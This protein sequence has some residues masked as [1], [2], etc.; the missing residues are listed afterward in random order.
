MVVPGLAVFGPVVVEQPTVQVL[1]TLRSGLPALGSG[2][3]FAICTLP[4]PLGASP[5]I[6]I[7]LPVKLCAPTAIR[8]LNVTNLG[9]ALFV[10]PAVV[11][12]KQ[13]PQTSPVVSHAVGAVTV[14][15]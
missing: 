4:M 5:P 3:G 10:V 2:A 9:L 11:T 8:A 13:T 12:L 7:E 6:A 14:T 15:P 1:T